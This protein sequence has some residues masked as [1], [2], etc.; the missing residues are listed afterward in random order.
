MLSAVKITLT[1]LSSSLRIF[2][3]CVKKQKPFRACT[4][5]TLLSMSQRRVTLPTRGRTFVRQFIDSTVI[6]NV[7]RAWQWKLHRS[8]DYRLLSSDTPPRYIFL[9]T[10]YLYYFLILLTHRERKM[11]KRKK[12]TIHFLKVAFC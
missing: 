8:L 4:C 1:K 11:I 7:Q 2:W 5:C 12:I 9:I 3:V 10:F 6:P